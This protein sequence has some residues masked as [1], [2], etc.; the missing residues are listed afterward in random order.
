[1]KPF[2]IDPKKGITVSKVSVTYVQPGENLPEELVVST[3]NYGAGDFL[4]IH[5][6]AS[7]WSVG[8]PEEIKNLLD[9]FVGRCGD[10]KLEPQPD[11][12]N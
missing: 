12:E 1:M 5:T 2:N 9:D 7:G 3:E 4:V 6:E 10:I 8:N 11:V